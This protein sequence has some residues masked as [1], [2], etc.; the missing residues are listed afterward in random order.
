MERSIEKEVQIRLRTI[1]QILQGSSHSNSERK[2]S[3]KEGLARLK[4]RWDGFLICKFL[5]IN[6]V[7]LPTKMV[8]FYIN[9]FHVFKGNDNHLKFI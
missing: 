4:K 9:N 3:K 6:G 7:L 8:Y 1:W 5:P 2:A